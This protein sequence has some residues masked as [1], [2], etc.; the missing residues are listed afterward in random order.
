MARKKSKKIKR[1]DVEKIEAQEESQEAKGKKTEAMEEL[2]RGWQTWTA[3]FEAVRDG[4]IKEM[5]TILNTDYNSR[6][7]DHLMGFGVFEGQPAT[8]FSIT[9]EEENRFLVTITDHKVE[10]CS[11]YKPLYASPDYPEVLY[12]HFLYEPNYFGDT[13]KYKKILRDLAK[14]IQTHEQD[15]LQ[16]GFSPTFVRW[17]HQSKEPFL[18]S[19]NENRDAIIVPLSKENKGGIVRAIYPCFPGALSFREL[20]VYGIRQGLSPTFVRFC[21]ELSF[22]TINEFKQDLLN[23]DTDHKLHAISSCALGEDILQY[24]GE[25]IVTAI[26]RRKNYEGDVSYIL[27]VFAQL[28]VEQ[29]KQILQN[30]GEQSGAIRISLLDDKL[31]LDVD[32]TTH[33]VLGGDGWAIASNARNAIIHVKGR[34]GC[35]G[36]VSNSTITVDGD[37]RGDLFFHSKNSEIT[38]SGNLYPGDSMFPYPPVI[39][40]GAENCIIRIEGRIDPG[41]EFGHMGNNVQIYINQRQILPEHLIRVDTGAISGHNTQWEKVYV[42]RI[43]PKYYP[44]FCF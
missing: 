12:T 1:T 7:L 33:V 17:Y 31:V 28:T 10:Y 5:Q 23:Y 16:R 32:A 24:T 37:Y 26:L 4:R 20:L 19:D 2:E 42:T 3:F 35:Y 44:I 14:E 11:D 36:H 15:L 21:A 38:I 8:K 13:R 18:T 22:G 29:F 40:E 25:E 41:S 27:D 34:G 43:N 6:C 39:G 30:A 9:Q